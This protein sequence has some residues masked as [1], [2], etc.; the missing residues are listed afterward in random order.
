MTLRHYTALQHKLDPRP[1]HP[2]VVTGE[3]VTLGMEAFG[4]EKGVT[5]EEWRQFSQARMEDALAAYIENHGIGFADTVVLDIEKDFSPVRS[6]SNMLA[7]SRASIACGAAFGEPIKR[8]LWLPSPRGR[9]RELLARD[10]TPLH[11]SGLF[12]RAFSFVAQAM[13][14]SPDRQ[15]PAPWEDVE[16]CRQ[17]A[18]NVADLWQGVIEVRPMLWHRTGLLRPRQSDNPALRSLGRLTRYDPE[19][20]CLRAMLEVFEERDE[21]E[22]VLWWDSGDHKRLLYD[23]E[24]LAEALDVLGVTGED[25]GGIGDPILTRLHDHETRLRSHRKTLRDFGIRIRELEAGRGRRGE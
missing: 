1:D 18:I 4:I 2:G 25:G 5:P 22:T 19:L 11:V 24:G 15:N 13:Y 6:M 10:Y 12:E 3:A 14:L 7:C 16:Q 21:I 23:H 20:N 17:D 9:P 8:G